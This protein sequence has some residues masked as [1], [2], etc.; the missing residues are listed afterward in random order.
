MIYGFFQRLHLGDSHGA[1]TPTQIILPRL[2]FSG[3]II[4]MKWSK[5]GPKLLFVANI[6]I[7]NH[8]WYTANS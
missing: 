6:V 1:K 5:N 3:H 7:L 4:P 8:L 2:A